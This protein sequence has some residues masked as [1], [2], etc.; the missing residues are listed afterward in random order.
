MLSTAVRHRT[1]GER[2]CGGQPASQPANSPS[3]GW[4]SL[5]LAKG[6]GVN[7]LMPIIVFPAARRKGKKGKGKGASC[8]RRQPSATPPV[9]QGRGPPGHG[10]SGS[11]AARSLASHRRPEWDNRGEGFGSKV[12]EAICV[13]SRERDPGKASRAPED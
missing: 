11:R 5:D 9:R 1:T 13:R 8:R 12:L 6:W 4:L 3:G 10:A 7:E 2:L